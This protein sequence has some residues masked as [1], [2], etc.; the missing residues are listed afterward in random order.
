M[1]VRTYVRACVCV[2][3]TQLEQLPLTSR[4]GRQGMRQVWSRVLTEH[5]AQGATYPVCLDEQLRC[6]CVCGCAMRVCVCMIGPRCACVD[7]HWRA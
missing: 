3:L 2:L 7:P 5:I 4:E 6:V 1:Y